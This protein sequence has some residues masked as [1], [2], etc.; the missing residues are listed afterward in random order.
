MST[1][2]IL[3]IFLALCLNTLAIACG[4]GLVR[5]IV[6]WPLLFLQL[7]QVS[8]KNEY[9]KIVQSIF[10]TCISD[11]KIQHSSTTYS[12]VSKVI[13]TK[14]G[15]NQSGIYNCNAK[16]ENEKHQIIKMSYTLDVKS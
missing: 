2:G 14:V 1:K 9:V 12:F 11:L 6:A 16:C 8:P 15:K 10:V 5:K 4:S 7:D 3:L 13:F